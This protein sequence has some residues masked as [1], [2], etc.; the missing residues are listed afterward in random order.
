MQRRDKAGDGQAFTR[1][2][3]LKQVPEYPFEP[4]ARALP[5]EPDGTSFIDLAVWVLAGEQMAHAFLPISPV[6]IMRRV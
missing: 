2:D 3:L 1:S 4:D 6:M 5:I